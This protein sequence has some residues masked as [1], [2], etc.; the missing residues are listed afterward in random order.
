M[1]HEE[2]THATKYIGNQS[3]INEILLTGGDP[4]MSLPL[5]AFTLSELT[6]NSPNIKSKNWNE[7]PSSRSK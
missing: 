7:S 2:I 6:S 4:L 5:L 1:K 3:E